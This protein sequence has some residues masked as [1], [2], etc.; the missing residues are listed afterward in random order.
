MCKTTRNPNVH[1]SLQELARLGS[2]V[3]LCAGQPSMADTDRENEKLE[4]AQ[5]GGIHDSS[6]FELPDGRAGCRIVLLITNQTSRAI[7]TPEV[8]LRTSSWEDDFFQ[9][10]EPL[11]IQ[12]RNSR[13]PDT[14]Y[15][16][17]RFPGPSGLELQYD[18]VLNHILLED[19]S[20]APERPFKGFLLAVGNLSTSPSPSLGRITRNTPKASA[21]GPNALRLGRKL[22]RGGATCSENR[23]VVT[24]GTLFARRVCIRRHHLQE[25][26]EVGDQVVIERSKPRNPLRPPR[27]SPLSPYFGLSV[28]ARVPPRKSGKTRCPVVGIRERHAPPMESASSGFS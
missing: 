4:I 7:H 27:P 15:Q 22:W 13:K 21:C 11:S 9:W 10:L 8:E 12:V 18:Q 1:A 14:S 19:Q 16:V 26:Q 23:S 17:Y 25:P 20:V 5:V 6:I 2:P 3:D 24:L 28:V